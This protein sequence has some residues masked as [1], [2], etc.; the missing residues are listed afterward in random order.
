M[1]VL[2]FPFLHKIVAVELINPKVCCSINSSSGEQPKG[3]ICWCSWSPAAL[4]GDYCS[5]CVQWNQ[6]CTTKTPHSTLQLFAGQKR[7]NILLWGNRA[8][9]LILREQ[10]RPQTRW[11]LTS[12]AR[13]T[14]SWVSQHCDSTQIQNRLALC[15]PGSKANPH[16]PKPFL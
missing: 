13:T 16:E 8:V 5:V 12:W 1:F 6:K 3:S 4:K 15:I 14:Q 11:A 10:E 7:C 2:S 9:Q